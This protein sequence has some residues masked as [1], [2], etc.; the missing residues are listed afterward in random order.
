VQRFPYGQRDYDFGRAM[1]S[2]RTTIGLT[3]AGLA[4]LLGVSRKAISRWEAGETY[5]KAE[6]LKALLVFALAQQ[7][8]PAGR[9]EEEI[10]TFWRSAHQKALLDERW[11]QEMLGKQPPRLTLVA[12]Q[13]VVETN[14]VLQ[15]MDRPVTATRVDWSDA[16]AA[17]SFYGRTEELAMLTQWVV[18]ERCRV[19][20][21]LGLGGI[22]KSALA[23][24]LMHQVAPHFEVVI[25][26]SVRDAPACE[27]LLDQCLQFLN[28]QSLGLVPTSLERRL[29][30]MLEHLRRTR[31]LLVLDNLETLHLQHGHLSNL[32]L[33]QLAIRGAF[34]QGVEM[35]ATSLAEAQLSETVFNEAFD[36][37]WAVAIS[38]DG[39]YWAAGSRRGEVRVW[40]EEGKL[41]HLAW[42]AHTDTV[43]ALAF[44]PDGRT[45]ATGSWDGSLK[46]WDIESDALLWTNWF[47][48][49][50]ECLA[51]APDGGALA[52]SGDDATV[53]LQ[54]DRPGVHAGLES[55]WE[56]GY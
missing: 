1:L 19:V 4:E 54:V 31:I 48:D 5:P 23:V 11:L 41:L 24:S 22:G 27:A 45:L 29:G 34:L 32:D 42:Q 53:Q 10:R 30:L 50:V 13:H 2:L 49:N 52:S 17:P 51:F 55:R 47:T 7:A 21:V 6:H 28:P 36:V 20:N 40:R 15:I 35:Q 46:L 39:Q 16:L 3:Q 14:N 8:F 9:E 56:R 37:P 12:S 33:S 43:R 25:W 18:E 26:R 44:S 38:R